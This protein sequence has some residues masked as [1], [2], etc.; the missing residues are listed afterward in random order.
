MHTRLLSPP[1]SP[2]APVRRARARLL[3]AACTRA[4]RRRSVRAAH[5]WPAHVHGGGGY[6]WSMEL[7]LTHGARGGVEWAAREPR[8][9]VRCEGGPQSAQ[10]ARA[11]GPCA[12][13]PHSQP[14][15]LG[16]IDISVISCAQWCAARALGLRG[17]RARVARGLRVQMHKIFWHSH[18]G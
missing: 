16:A 5:P 15:I 1:P 12:P 8:T 10:I 7:V 13:L 4:M 18:A 6:L 3:T 14:M 11:T 9:R 17:S 2:A